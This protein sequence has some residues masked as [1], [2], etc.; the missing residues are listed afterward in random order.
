MPQDVKTCWNSIYD[1]LQFALEHREALKEL[2]ERAES[3][4]D[5]LNRS[6]CATLTY[7]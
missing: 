3:E 2:T 1:M 7:A 5:H 6:N 4:L